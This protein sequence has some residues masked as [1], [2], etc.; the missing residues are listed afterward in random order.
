MARHR[1]YFTWKSYYNF[2]RIEVSFQ[3]ILLLQSNAW[4]E[5]KG[6]STRS[7]TGRRTTRLALQNSLTVFSIYHIPINP[8][9]FDWNCI[10]TG[11]VVA[12][13]CATKDPV[14]Y[15]E[16]ENHQSKWRSE[17]FCYCSYNF[18]NGGRVTGRNF[19]LI[20][21]SLISYFTL[22]DIFLSSA[23]WNEWDATGD[24]SLFIFLKSGVKM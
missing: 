4:R 17:E 18:C 10:F 5:L 7:V 13:G 16:C 8:N 6:R 9:I 3:E 19:C 15:V 2:T 23:N 12:R 1:L 11:E 22:S 14:Y 24:M 20:C 21:L